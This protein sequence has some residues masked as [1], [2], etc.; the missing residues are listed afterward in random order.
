[1]ADWPGFRGTNRDG[2]VK[3]IKISTDWAASPPEEIW[4]KPVGPGCS[5]FA[6]R[7][8]RLYT[9]EQLGE[10]ETVSCYRL[11]TGKAI[12]K[13]SDNARFEESHAGPGP[14]STP[15]LDGNHLIIKSISMILLFIRDMPML[16]MVRIL[17][18]SI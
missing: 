6:V 12:W 16:L 10:N 11:T 8:D 7:G 2:I 18:A 3:G 9:Q 17:H 13:H 1:M 15:T 4:R 5:S 14:R